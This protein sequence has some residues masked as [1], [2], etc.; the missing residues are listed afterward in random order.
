MQDVEVV[1]RHIR[2]ASL[3]IS[4]S[5]HGIIVAQAY[6]RPWVWWRD[7]RGL[8]HGGDFKFEDFFSSIE[9]SPPCIECNGEITSRLVDKAITMATLAPHAVTQQRQRDLLSNA[10]RILDTPVLAGRLM[11]VGTG[12]LGIGAA[13][14]HTMDP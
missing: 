13:P 8:L 14:L 7:N 9:V 5:L 11:A 10:P 2:D 12:P 6:G 1:V 4:S 3:V